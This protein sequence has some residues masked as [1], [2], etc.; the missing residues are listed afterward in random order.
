MRTWNQLFV[1]VYCYH[2][3]A[4]IGDKIW[5]KENLL[6]KYRPYKNTHIIKMIGMTQELI[7]LLGSA[8]HSV[9][10]YK[11]FFF[12]KLVQYPIYINDAIS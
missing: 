9:P 6:S 12:M 4:I 5:I 8:I 7:V 2:I 3:Y 11:R 1:F 10:T